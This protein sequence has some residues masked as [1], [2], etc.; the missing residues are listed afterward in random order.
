MS[1]DLRELLREARNYIVDVRETVDWHNQAIVKRIDAALA[2]KAPEPVAWVHGWEHRYGDHPGF[3]AQ[4]SFIHQEHW[5]DEYWKP[6]WDHPP[7]AS[8]SD[9]R[10]AARYRW[11]MKQEDDSLLVCNVTD[12]TIDLAIDQEK[13]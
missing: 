5:T 11:L 2:E 9:A 3:S 8:Q 10:D 12:E 4:V 1:E 7:A 6:L 13:P